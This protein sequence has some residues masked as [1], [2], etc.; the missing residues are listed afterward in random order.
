MDEIITLR[1]EIYAESE[2]IK[3]LSQKMYVIE[4]ESKN[5][6]TEKGN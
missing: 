4:Q 5:I 6:I 1:N 2:K 3:C